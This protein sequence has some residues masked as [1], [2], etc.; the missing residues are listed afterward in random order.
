MLIH[1][2][3]SQQRTPLYDAKKTKKIWEKNASKTTSGK[4]VQSWRIETEQFDA[5]RT[6]IIIKFKYFKW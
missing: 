2:L 6:K 5:K 3:L 4:V 1:Y